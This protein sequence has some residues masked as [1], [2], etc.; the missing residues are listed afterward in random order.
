VNLF[1]GFDFCRKV[2]V[3]EHVAGEEEVPP[4]LLR[5]AEG[6][7]GIE[8][9]G[10]RLSPLPGDIISDDSLASASVHLINDHIKNSEGSLLLAQ[11]FFRVI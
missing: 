2:N 4:D 11:V 1:N 8:E 10:V 7:I 9:T 5:Y 3:G 6:Q